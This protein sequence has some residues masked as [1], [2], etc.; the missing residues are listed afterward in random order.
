[1]ATARLQAAT[2]PVSNALFESTVVTLLTA[3]QRNM[4]NKEVYSV[5]YIYRFVYR[6]VSLESS[7]AAGSVSG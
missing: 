3:L 7:A 2:P 6:F 5:G 1:M 4:L